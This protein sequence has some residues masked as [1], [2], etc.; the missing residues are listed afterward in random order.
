MTGQALLTLAAILTVTGNTVT[1]S[2]QSP[3][4]TGRV[5]ARLPLHDRQDV[6]IRVWS[7]D[8]HRQTRFAVIAEP[9]PFTL[10]ADNMSVE[11]GQLTFRTPAE[12]T[13]PPGPMAITLLSLPGEPELWTDV[14]F[15][16]GDTFQVHTEGAELSFEWKT[17]A[18]QGGTSDSGGEWMSI[19]GSRISSSEVLRA[20]D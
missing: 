19:I 5:K 13:I 18:R 14:I 16:A 2:T 12:I 3:S 15:E 8:D 9:W 10:T 6:T 4:T 17:D 20:L 7:S 1:Q 11:Q